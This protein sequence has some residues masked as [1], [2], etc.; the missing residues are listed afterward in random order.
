M[1]R[2]RRGFGG[3]LV[4]VVLAI[5]G[6]ALAA[7]AMWKVTSP[8]ATLYLFGTMHLL[9]DD[10]SWRTPAFDAAYAEAKDVWFETDMNAANDP[11]VAQGLILQYGL[12]PDHPLSGK[13]DAK[14]LAALKATLAPMKL[15]FAGVNRMQPWAAA[16]LV[17]A[18]PMTVA[19]FDPK[20]GADMTLTASALADHKTIRTFETL[21]QQI[22]LFSSMGE[23]AQVQ[24]LDDTVA[25]AGKTGAETKAMQAAWLSGDIQRLGVLSLAEMQKDYPAFYE[26]LI[27]H[28]NAA[29]ANA[30]T[31]EL[32][33]HDTELVNVGALHMVGDAGLP[34]LLKARGFEVTRVQ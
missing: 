16:L 21:D 10:A 22:Q 28:R 32:A 11:S 14:H 33:G 12:D 23:P 31:Q 5:A 8:T 13:L 24:M 26:A 4:A 2:G 18:K 34:A 15:P 30:L 27:A 17:M 25:D 3:V 29:W 9:T 20:A 1:S 7:P 19:G 6:P